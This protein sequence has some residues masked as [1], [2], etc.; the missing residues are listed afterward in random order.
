MASAE[1]SQFPLTAQ[2][3]VARLP[4]LMQLA[5]FQRALNEEFDNSLHADRYRTGAALGRLRAGVELLCDLQQ[6]VLHPALAATREAA[7]PALQQAMRDA[8]ALRELAVSADRTGEAQQ[9]ALVSLLAGLVQL[10]LAG[11]DELLATADAARMPWGTLTAQTH[12]LL[13]AW[14]A[15]QAPGE[16]TLSAA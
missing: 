16:G 14:P 8:A 11:L 10:Q 15:L 4:L 7:W 6:D 3:L 13:H 1:L 9:R 12:R 5:D 2:G